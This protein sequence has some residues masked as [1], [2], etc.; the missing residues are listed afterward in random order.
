M[1]VTAVNTTENGTVDLTG[2]TIT[3]TPSANFYGSASFKYVV[4]DGSLVDTGT[5][6]V[7]VNAINDKPVADEQSVTTEEDNAL[8]ITLT[9]NDVDEDVLTYSK[10][11]DPSHGSVSFSENEVTYTPSA[12]YN[13]SDSFTFKVNDGVLDSDTAT[14]SITITAVNDPPVLDPISNKTVDE[15]TNLTFTAHATDPDNTVSYSLTNAPTGATINS[16]TGVFSFTPTE[17]QG[18][19]SYTLT[20]N[21]TDGTST[22]SEEITIT[23]NEVNVAPIADNISTSTNEDTEKIINLNATDSDLPAND[24]SYSEVTSPSHGTVSISNDQVAYTPAANYNGAD[25][26]T[27]S[28][29]DDVIDSLPATV[30]ITISAVNDFPSAVSDDF[31]T[32]EDTTYAIDPSSLITNDTDVDGNTL[33]VSAVSNPLHGTVELENANPNGNNIIFT[34]EAN[35]N[36]PASFDYTVTDGNL[37]DTATVT[38]TYNPINDAPVANPDSASVN[39]DTILTIAKSTLLANDTDIESSSLNLTAVSNPVNG[40]VVIDGTNVKFTPTNN[41]SGSASFVYTIS[42]GSL[43]DT[44]T[45]TITVNPINDKP[46]A[47][48]DVGF[49]TD[50]ENTLEIAPDELLDNDAD[51]DEDTI[52]ITDV[53]NPVNGTVELDIENDNITFI[54]TANYFGPASFDYTISDGELTD[55]ATVSITVNS[56]N[57]LPVAT[58]GSISTDEN[59]AKAITL[60]ATDTDLPV[61]TLTY[62]I[63]AN[64]LHGTLST[65]SGNQITYTPSTNYSGADLFTFKANDGTNDS[66]TATINIVINNTMPPTV[67]KL[68]DGTSDFILEAEEADLIFSENLSDNSKTA[69]ESALTAG[70]DKVLSYSWSN[71]TLTIT[72]TET[73]TF[74]N[75][76]VVNVSDVAGNTANSLLIVDSSLTTTQTTPDSDG[77][78]TADS[79]SPEVVITDPDDEV[80][81]TVDGDTEAKIDVSSFINDDGDGNIPKITINSDDAEVDIPATKVTGPT[82]WDGVIAAPTVTTIT[83]PDISGETLTTST[84]IEIG[85]ATDKLSFDNAVRILLPGQAGKR[86]GY[87][88]PGTAFT[89]ITTI[90]S[91][92]SQTAGDA[93]GVDGECKINVDLDLVIWTKHFTKFA[94][95]TQTTNSTSSSSSTSGGGTTTASAPVCNDTKPASAPFGLTAISGLNSVTLTWNKASDPVSYYLVT[96]GTSSGSQTYGNPNVGGSS[97]TSY[98]ITNL[99]GGATY[100]FKVRAGNGCKPGDFSNEASATP[101]GGF[102][103]GV[104]PGFEAGVLGAA[105]ESANLAGKEPTPTATVI[106]A[107]LV[108]GIQTV[109]KNKLMK[110]IF[111]IIL[112]I[113]LIVLVFYF[114]KKRKSV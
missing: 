105:T 36:G 39:E 52:S 87:S 54:P 49:E 83:L 21:A 28:A 30:T 35:Y 84:A 29:N 3:F 65:I 99:S 61:Q 50:E 47:E 19:G 44:T 69:I 97:T 42:D 59:V 70:A 40:S 86:A 76:V 46:V 73:T 60:S 10:T 78:A 48:N 5:V 27:Y 106:N 90:C 23:V 13:G 85:Y 95:Y 58:N 18:P 102:V 96:Y 110:Y 9:G 53:S 66:N 14:V 26:F 45:V 20:V 4:S 111:P 98:T 11:S 91:S 113:L 93:L 56:I 38:I 6:T 114:Y 108:K 101:S 81:V 71:G 17:A 64:P 41:Y 89:E 7:T 74:A 12:N 62:S 43:T 75:D 31:T 72:S 100:Y 34:P 1:T 79:D 92:D 37:T 8:L 32:N 107:G 57:D 2:S 55:T 22:D 112:L 88:R 33:T 24:I 109:S 80:T 16:S 82:G 103:E 94:A 77:E 51:V 68:G 104:A 15:Q 63:D 67:T 25:S